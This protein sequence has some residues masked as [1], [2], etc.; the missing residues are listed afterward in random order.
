MNKQ[1]VGMKFFSNSMAQVVGMLLALVMVSQSAQ[2][3][4]STDQTRYI[5]RGDSDALTITVTNNDKARTFGGRP[6]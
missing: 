5:F 2:A 6:G 1:G 3:S 4:L